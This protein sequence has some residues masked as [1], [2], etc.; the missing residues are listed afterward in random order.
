MTDF[1]TVTDVVTV[2]AP[3]QRNEPGAGQVLGFGPDGVVVAVCRVWADRSWHIGHFDVSN[4]GSRKPL[5]GV[6][7]GVWNRV[8][9]VGNVR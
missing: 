4:I 1:F 6:R 3:F 8:V 9:T 7:F 5:L 2:P